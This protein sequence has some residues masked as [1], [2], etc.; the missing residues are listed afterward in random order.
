M[1]TVLSSRLFSSILI[2]VSIKSFQSSQNVCFGR[3]SHSSHRRRDEDDSV[4]AYEQHRDVSLRCLQQSKRPLDR[5]LQKAQILITMSQSICFRL[6]FSNV[7]PQ[8]G[9]DLSREIL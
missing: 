9:A 4:A 3:L 1:P 2:F 5:V 8:L 7:S 6:T